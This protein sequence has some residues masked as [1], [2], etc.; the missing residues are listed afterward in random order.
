LYQGGGGA[1]TGILVIVA[2]GGM[3]IA[4]HH[5]ADMPWTNILAG[6]LSVRSCLPCSHAG[7]DAH[8]ALAD[9]LRVL[10][11]I[12]LPVLLLYPLGTV[13]L[14]QSDGQAPAAGECFSDALKESK[15]QLR[16]LAEALQQSRD[17]LARSQELAHIGTWE[18][19]LKTGN[20]AWTDEVYRIFGMKPRNC[21]HL[22]VL[23]ATC[24]S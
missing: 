15:E 24:T 12:T 18:L 5:P 22:R 7:F 10:G 2:T 4:W 3:G 11:A 1:F 14:R 20:L 6:V 9:S 8:L 16:Q 21:L 13:L 23:S 19:D 17:L